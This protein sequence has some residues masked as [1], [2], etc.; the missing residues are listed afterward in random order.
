M[1]A[2]AVASATSGS[3][4]QVGASRKNGCVG[5]VG[6]AQQQRALAEVVQEQRR[7]HEHEPR[8]PDRPL[9]EVPHVGVQRLAAGD[10]EEDGAEHRETRASRCA[11]KKMNACRGS[12]APQ[13]GRR[14]AIQ[15]DARARR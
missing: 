12:S 1:I 13:H 9:A 8:E 3:S 5:G 11:R 7:Q 14:A 6:F 10:D 15:H 2:A 4:A